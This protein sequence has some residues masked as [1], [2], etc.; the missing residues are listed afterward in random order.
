MSNGFESDHIFHEE[1]GGGPESSSDARILR[2]EDV[3]AD[4]ES[5][6]GTQKINTDDTV[7]QKE[8]ATI[9][10][11]A[12]RGS[13]NSESPKSLFARAYE[14]VQ[15][16]DFV[17]RVK[18]LYTG[19]HIDAKN[20]QIQQLEANVEAQKQAVTMQEQRLSV[21]D[22][23]S[24]TLAKMQKILKTKETT[25][26]Q[27]EDRDLEYAS[28]QSRAEAHR[29]ALQDA[30]RKLEVAKKKRSEFETARD[31]SRNR[32]AERVQKNVDTNVSAITTL[33][34]NVGEI[35]LNL[36]VADEILLSLIGEKQQ[37]EHIANTPEALSTDKQTARAF[38]S[39]LE[40][41]IQDMRSKMQLQT[42]QIARYEEKKAA[43]ETQKLKLEKK[44]AKKESVSTA[45]VE[46]TAGEDVA[47][48]EGF[49]ANTEEYIAE[50]VPIGDSGVLD[51]TLPE[52]VDSYK[53]PRVELLESI[54]G[55]MGDEEY[56]KYDDADFQ[57]EVEQRGTPEQK[58]LL[59]NRIF[60]KRL[61]SFLES[62]TRQSD[63]A[64]FN[65]V[66]LA[67]QYDELLEPFEEDSEIGTLL[68]PDNR[69]RIE[70]REMG[71]PTQQLLV[72]I[73]NFF[74]ELFKSSNI[75]PQVKKPD[76]KI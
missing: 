3:R 76:E 67:T 13:G 29:V 52:E 23:A 64:S 10:T 32:I 57:K 19:R 43:L 2:T 66:I 18:I 33:D 69:R 21:S 65:P 44:I 70:K 6:A 38:A 36:G 62:P 75:R 72:L 63:Q 22:E 74:E 15:N 9:D 49:V 50:S 31:D 7:V 68:D 14:A 42:D 53:D 55:L 27:R 11:S 17:D 16:T 59:Q 47:K 12:E 5:L 20:R 4:N 30:E 8:V 58:L 48:Q 61:F 45:H 28:V 56:K 39:E 40:G 35:Q 25:S 24:A 1:D 37:A 54:R 51:I 60:Q 73:L 46:D 26:G 41:R 71:T 34:S